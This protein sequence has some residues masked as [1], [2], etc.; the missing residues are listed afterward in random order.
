MRITKKEFEDAQK[1]CKKYKT[2]IEK[3]KKQEYLL[4]IRKLRNEYNN[5]KKGDFIEIL[6]DP[7]DKRRTLKKGEVLTVFD[8]YSRNKIYGGAQREYIT[9]R[10]KRKNQKIGYVFISATYISCDSGAHFDD[11]Y[12]DTCF[13]ILTK[14]K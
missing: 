11:F 1:I 2:Q 12:E 4:R 9:I 13:K 7:R 10:A 14:S 8:V 5:L 6:S 3:E